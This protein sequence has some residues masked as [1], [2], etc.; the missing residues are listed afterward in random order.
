MCES[1]KILQV[2]PVVEALLQTKDGFVES[3]DG[4]YFPSA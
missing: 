3:H 2:N 4:S 1:M